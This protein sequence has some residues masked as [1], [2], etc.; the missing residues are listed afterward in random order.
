MS[1]AESAKSFTIPDDLRFDQVLAE[2]IIRQPISMSFDERGRLWVVQ[3]IQYPHPAGLKVLSRDQFWRAVYDKVPP[4]PPHQFRGLDRI[5]IHEDTTG[6]GVYD[7]HNV[8]IDGLNIVTS[9]AFGR[10]GVW[11]LN[12]PYLL[13]YPDQE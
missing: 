11:V 7:K 8:F 2:P 9:I 12:P 6:T 10:G 13:F 1:P 3:Y 5:T 4:P